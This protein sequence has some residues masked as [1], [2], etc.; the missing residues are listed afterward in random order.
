MDCK[1]SNML[2]LPC[3]V[4]NEK[5]NQLVLQY[6]SPDL[7]MNS[8]LL[9]QILQTYGKFKKPSKNLQYYQG[10]LLIYKI[11]LIFIVVFENTDLRAF[12]FSKNDS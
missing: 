3:L 4:F 2:L 10:K 5:V 1:P 12:M 6:L 9:K 8:T 11:I 7:F